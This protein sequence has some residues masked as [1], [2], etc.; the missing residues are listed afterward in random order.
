M[1]V[2]LMVRVNAHVHSV[3]HFHSTLLNLHYICTVPFCFRI[4]TKEKHHSVGSS[5]LG[6]TCNPSILCDSV[7]TFGSSGKATHCG[8]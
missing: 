2:L 1:S 3:E 4:T 7:S 6:I 8:T 5:S